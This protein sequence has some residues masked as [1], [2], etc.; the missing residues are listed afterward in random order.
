MGIYDQRRVLTKAQ[1][2]V[3]IEQILSDFV[4]GDSRR[5]PDLS[6]LRKANTALAEIMAA[7][8]L[9]NP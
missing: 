5:G 4:P 2:Q 7:I 3:E 6:I 9:Y 8:E 1:L